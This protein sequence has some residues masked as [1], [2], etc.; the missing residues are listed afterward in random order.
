MLGEGSTFGRS[1]QP[2]VDDCF[3]SVSPLSY[4]CVWTLEFKVAA[5]S[6]KLEIRLHAHQVGTNTRSDTEVI[7][8]LV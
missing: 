7:F 3:Q 2:S 4:K 5:T 8:T 1:V 6:S